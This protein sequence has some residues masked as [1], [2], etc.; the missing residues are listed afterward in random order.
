MSSML[1]PDDLKRLQVEL[2]Y[3]RSELAEAREKKRVADDAFAGLSLRAKNLEDRIKQLELDSTTPTI[4]EH[5]LLRYLERVKGVDLD[6]VRVEM[7]KPSTIK[8]IDFVRTG[9]VPVQ[10]EEYSY[11]VKNRTVCTVTTKDGQE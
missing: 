6:A 3:A 8:T 11:V 1:K 4:S 5:A 10:G 7:L 2:R 9:R